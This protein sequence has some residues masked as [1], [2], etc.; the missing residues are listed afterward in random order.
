M[1]KTGFAAYLPAPPLCL[2]LLC[3]IAAGQTFAQ[4]KLTSPKEHFGFD[5][6]DDYQLANYTQYEAYIKKLDQESE[7]MKVIE[8]GKSAEGR[9]MYVGIITAPENFKKLDRYKE[10]SRKLAL[11]EG[12]T[13]EQARQLAKEGKAIVWIDGGLHATEVLGAQQLIETVWQLN[14]RTDEEALRFLNDTI[15]LTCLVNPDGMELV[16]NWYMREQDPLKRNTSSIPRLY[17]KYI[18]H[19]DNRD[20]YMSTQPETENINRVFFQEWFPHIVYN[21][22]QTGPAGTVMFA[23]PFRDPFN[24]TFDP[25]IPLGI[26]LPPV[27][28]RVLGAEKTPDPCSDALPPWWEIQLAPLTQP[29]YVGAVSA[30]PAN[31]DPE[32]YPFQVC[33]LYPANPQAR[34]LNPGAL[35]VA[36][37]PA[38]TRLEQVVLA[39][40]LD[41]D[42]APDVVLI[43]A[44]CDKPE[45][46][47]KNCDLTCRKTWLRTGGQWKVIDAGTPC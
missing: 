11:A 31:E 41:A 20:F 7:R 47:L 15:V 29:E 43:Q 17:Q 6:G 27:Q 35:D 10:I 25:M 38:G 24:Y 40:D 22:H 42:Q 16:S 5:I 2:M 34:A 44:C 32:R 4:N 45:L 37:L 14:S 39:L 28:S 21:H 30:A 19:D 46:P 36:T 26:D 1:R 12:L 18:G 33:V 8:I 9:T 13:N 23:P 3:L